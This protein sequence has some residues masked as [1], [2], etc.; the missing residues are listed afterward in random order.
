M[1]TL[2]GT[3][4]NVMFKGYVEQEYGLVIGF[5]QWML[6]GVPV[7]V[8]MLAAMWWGMT[9]IL[10]PCRMER[11]DGIS[12]LI[13]A[14]LEALGR[15]SAG[16]KRTLAVFSVTA[17]LWIFGQTLE[18]YIGVAFNDASIAIAAALALFILPSGMKKGEK[19]MTWKDTKE[20][21]W[22]ILLLLAGGLTMAHYM[23]GSGVADWLGTQLATLHDVPLWVIVLLATAIMIFITELMSNVAALTALLPVIAAVSADMGINPMLLAV[24]LTLTASCSFMLPIGTPPNAIVFGSGLLKIRHMV[25]AGVVYD[26]FGILLINGLC[27]IIVPLVF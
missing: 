14:R 5:G 25:R 27:A 10:F 15:M 16:E 24:P 2:V 6:I 23:D 4:T 7:G 8:T 20:M 22:G 21:P 18:D 1:M 17:C 9:H 3:S 11:H 13:D 26:L 12:T 19:L